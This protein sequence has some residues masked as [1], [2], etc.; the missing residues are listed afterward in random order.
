ME[1]IGLLALKPNGPR[2]QLPALGTAHGGAGHLMPEATT[3]DT[4]RRSPVSLQRLAGRRV[5]CSHEGS[6][7]LARTLDVGYHVSSRNSPA[8]LAAGRLASR[9]TYAIEL[10]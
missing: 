1:P 2:A 6:R 4:A 9:Q 7:F 5:G 8:D 10:G 3:P